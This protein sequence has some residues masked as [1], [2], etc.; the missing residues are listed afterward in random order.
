[1]TLTRLGL[2][3]DFSEPRW[4]G[5]DLAGRT[6]LLYTEGG[7][8]DALQFVR[9]ARLVAQRGGIVFLECQPELRDLFGSVAGVTRLLS[10]G[11]PLPPFDVH[12]PLQSL[13]LALGTNLQS[14]PNSVPYLVADPDR[15]A[16]WRRQLLADGPGF[17]VGLVWSGSPKNLPAHNP[18]QTLANFSPWAGIKGVVFYSLQ[19]GIPEAEARNPP[20]G[21][22]L[23]DYSRRLVDFAD[24]AALVTC[25]DLV[26]SVDTSVAH[27]AGALGRPAWVMLTTLPD[28]RWLL[29]RDDSPWY[30]SVRLFRQTE[31]DDWSSVV[32]RVAAELQRVICQAAGIEVS[33]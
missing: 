6:I 31:R 10:R 24:T 5:A 33:S 26:I 16:V 15:I 27:L 11:E 21:L 13:P 4:D 1:L 20:R 28:F 22:N 8:G 25:L 14:I 3:R 32:Q 23:I 9:Y 19:K 2:R 12:S 7:F 30:P 17:R 29:N 18:N